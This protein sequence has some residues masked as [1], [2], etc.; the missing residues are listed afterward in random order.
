M[1]SI[2]NNSHLAKVIRGIKGICDRELRITNGKA[3]KHINPKWSC[4]QH[5]HLVRWLLHKYKYLWGVGG[6]SYG[7]SLQDGALHTYT[8]RLG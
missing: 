5:T 2:I 7:S 1:F 8:L 3:L 4:H 6:K